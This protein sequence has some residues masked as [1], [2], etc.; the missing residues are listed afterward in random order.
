MRVLKTRPAARDPLASG[1]FPTPFRCVLP[2]GA[3]FRD[4]PDGR[5]KW[6]AAF[7]EASR[8]A[9]V[10]LLLQAVFIAGFGLGQGDYYFYTM[11][12]GYEFYAHFD[13]IDIRHG[14]IG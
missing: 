6:E 14:G 11:G 13:G 2:A 7:P 1:P 9:W 3:D 12:D 5:E 10:T 8:D 4:C